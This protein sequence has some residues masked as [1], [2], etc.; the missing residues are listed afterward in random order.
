MPSDYRRGFKDGL[1]IG[2]GYLSVS[3]SFGILAVTSGLTW[4]QAVLISFTNLTSAG[5]VAGVGIMVGGG[6]ALEMAVTTLIINIRYALM[7]ISLTQKADPSMTPPARALTAN[8]ITDEVFGVASGSDVPVTTAYMFGLG[9]LPV[10]GW[11]LGTL[12][13]AV[14]GNILPEMV[15][16][17][18]SIGIYGMVI[19]I[20]LPV[21][22]KDKAVLIVSLISCLLS[23][24]FFYI[25]V[26]KEKVSSGFAIIICSVTASVLGAVFMPSKEVE[27][28]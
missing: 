22:K 10:I 4:W 16:S 7:S 12:L 25:P 5:Q 21:C 8:F 15:V 17:C 18:L 23:I 13:G 27:Y 9:T 2:L 24:C 26:L 3:F 6:G 19:A 20:I 28:E 14:C 1:A 11:T